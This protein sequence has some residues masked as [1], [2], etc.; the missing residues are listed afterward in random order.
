MRLRRSA[1]GL[2]ALNAAMVVVA[3]LSASGSGVTSRVSVAS[4]GREGNSD[5][6]GR[7]AISADG[8][9]VAFQ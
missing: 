3:A 4:D 9:F 8:R 6:F 7:S 5:G 2:V 1:A